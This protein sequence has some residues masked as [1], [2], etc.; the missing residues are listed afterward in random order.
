M[1]SSLKADF[2]SP[3]YNKVP[4]FLFKLNLSFLQDTKISVADTVVISSSV[5]D[6]ELFFSDPDTT[7]HMAAGAS[8]DPYLFVIAN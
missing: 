4:N 1:Y 2:F 3:V 8:P 6:P 5:V 7:F